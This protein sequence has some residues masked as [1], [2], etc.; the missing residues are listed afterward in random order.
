MLGVPTGASIAATAAKSSAAS[1]A[2]DAKAL[3]G[4]KHGML[5]PPQ[6]VDLASLQGKAATSTQT[7]GAP[8]RPELRPAA[9]RA[10]LSTP[11]KL[12]KVLTAP[13]TDPSAPTR[14]TAHTV[15]GAS[16][17]GGVLTLPFRFAGISVATQI[18]ALGQDQN[19]QPPDTQVALGPTSYVEAVNE[20]LSVWSRAGQR[21]LL[22]DLNRF[23]SAPA[24]S[25]FDSPRVSYDST[26]GHFFLSG[27]VFTAA[28]ATTEY[29]AV[30]QTSNPI[31]QWRVYKIRVSNTIFGDSPTMGFNN[32]V[33]VVSWADYNQSN[34]FI[35][36]ET[37]VL[38][39]A[40]LISG[41]AV[42]HTTF[43]PDVNRAAIVPAVSATA[44]ETEYL[45]FNNSCG[46]VQTSAS[47][48]TAATPTIGLI[49]ITGS[50][51]APGGIT[52]HEDD[53]AVTAPTDSPPDAVEM[54]GSS[55]VSTGD[56]RLR[57]VMYANGQVY[58]TG[59]DACTP[60]TDLELR[61][62]ARVTQ[63]TVNGATPTV[64]LDTA[65]ATPYD[66]VFDPAVAADP[67]GNIFLATNVIGPTVGPNIV[68][69]SIA[70]GT[71][72]V[73]AVAVYGHGTIFRGLPTDRWGHYSSAAVDPL[74]P[75]DIVL[76]AEMNTIPGAAMW[77][78]GVGLVTMATPS[79][80]A[81]SPSAG[82][83]LSGTNIT[84]TGHDF[85]PGTT[86]TFG[87]FPAV[88]T[89]FVS[90]NSL[91]AVA[92]AHAAGP[93]DVQV[94]TPN[95]LSPLVSADT[96]TYRHVTALA[97]LA[98]GVIS[99][100]PGTGTGALSNIRL[101]KSGFLGTTALV[102]VGDFDGDGH[103]DLAARD[104]AGALWLYSGNGTGSFPTRRKIGSGWN[105]LT[106]IVGPGDFDGDAHPDIIARTSTGSLVLYP[107]SGTGGFLTP[108]VI[109]AG[110]GSL[111]AIVA[112]GDFDSDGHNDLIV[113]SS[114]GAMLLYPGN[115]TG[116]FL[117]AR[118]VGSGWSSF[119]VITGVGDFTGDGHPDL[120]AR[121]AAGGLWLYPGAGTGAI[122]PGRAIGS[123]WSS[124]TFV[125]GIGDPSL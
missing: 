113:R 23:F 104:T 12:P 81:V 46:N 72:A 100:Y 20:S 125:L 78:T 90:P 76:A 64:A 118:V 65:I 88:T 94:S 33:V 7:L 3:A 115:G 73:S 107:G 24:G 22:V 109:G 15:A 84:I 8:V 119:N 121:T 70:A 96:Y 29:V 26:T 1:A 19:V 51:A 27:V 92:P 31:G 102:S 105:S 69:Y 120:V 47:N 6:I 122:L 42:A 111:T 11:R 83:T 48:C 112:P 124:Y 63:V 16:A 80:T 57:S 45:A 21:L 40:Q 2:A 66:Y 82:T 101:V 54:F 39:K 32:K 117:A 28:G 4:A 43:G 53:P 77:A 56:D 99:I 106:A 97:T 18:A 79:V 59:G 68:A 93:V 95:G 114:A 44:T 85:I 71:H 52:W 14:A 89:T 91:V 61:A 110:W 103:T 116:R 25:G 5:A 41:S 30:S 75:Y 35:G 123:G 50:P 87:G 36:Q 108:R 10:P 37:W 67:D 38:D 58:T 34:N 9:R 98:N 49:S 60:A 74:N 17:T 55:A 13:V 62:C 86:V